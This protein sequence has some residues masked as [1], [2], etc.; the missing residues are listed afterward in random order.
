MGSGASRVRKI[1]PKMNDEEHYRNLLLEKSEEIVRLKKRNY[2]LENGIQ[3]RDEEI[4]R[5]KKEIDEK[6]REID[7]LRQSKVG[8]LYVQSCANNFIGLYRCLYSVGA[9]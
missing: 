6:T 8:G 4:R 3:K 7:G 9:V 1:G 2:D 5:L